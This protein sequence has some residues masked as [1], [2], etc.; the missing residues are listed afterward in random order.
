MK[1]AFQIKKRPYKLIGFTFFIFFTTTHCGFSQV[2]P[3]S[4]VSFS[5]SV[6]PLMT[7]NLIADY[8]DYRGLSIQ[9]LINRDISKSFQLSAGVEFETYRFYKTFR[10]TVATEE[11]D[12]LGNWVTVYSKSGE[13]RAEIT[14]EKFISIPFMINF[15]PKSRRISPYF[16]IGGKLAFRY[17]DQSRESSFDWLKESIIPY[18]IRAKYPSTLPGFEWLITAKSGLS[19]HSTNWSF[20]SGVILSRNLAKKKHLRRLSY[21]V[22]F[23]LTYHLAPKLLRPKIKEDPKNAVYFQF[24]GNA[25]FYSF[26]YERRIGVEGKSSVWVRGG[27]AFFPFKKKHG[28]DFRDKESIPFNWSITTGTSDKFFRPHIFPFSLNYVYGDMHQFELG[29]G[30]THCRAGLD[31]VV[32]SAGYRLKTK[33][34]YLFKANFTPLFVYEETRLIFLSGISF[35]KFF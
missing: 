25:L 33:K 9:H 4:K 32:P 27:V 23:Q 19:Y 1:K 3:E 26:N 29:L 17:W 24:K 34:N 35:G 5:T 31:A 15:N 30:Y 6:N 16:G 28:I 21:G 22:N 10:E 11:Q 7:S 12:S 2:N 18:S 13:L 14:Q 8:E 20:S